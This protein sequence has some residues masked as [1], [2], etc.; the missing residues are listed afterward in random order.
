MR[1]T[2]TYELTERLRLGLE[3]NPQGNDLGIVGNWRVLDETKTRPAIILGTS[4][5]RIGTEDGRAFYA[6]ASK[7]LSTELGLPIAPYVGVAWDGGDDKLQDIGGLAVRWSG[8]VS[9]THFY[10]GENLH[11]LLS[12]NSDVGTFGLVLADV[13]DERY[14]GATV[15]VRF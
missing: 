3:Y 9:S 14:V 12:L 7:D 5:A 13:E 11:H 10:D 8:R 15:S 2:L 6:T 4:S 1:T